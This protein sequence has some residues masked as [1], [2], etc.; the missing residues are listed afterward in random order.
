MNIELRNK[1]VTEA[2]SQ[3]L[4]QIN[5]DL[6]YSTNFRYKMSF[7]GSESSTVLKDQSSV[8]VTV[9]QLLFSGEW[10]LGI[11][12]SK[13]A[14]LIASQQVDVT[15]LDIKETVYNSY[16]TILVSER[17]MEIVKAEPGKYEPDT[18]SY[19]KYAGSRYCRADRRRSDPHHCRTVEKQPSGY[20]TDSRRKL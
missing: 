13:I 17:L 8:G 3:G 5:G 18:A 15:E 20:A 2:I 12:T 9:N 1:M 10:I 6:N 14:K 11:Q 16:Y 4:P 19:R 7:P